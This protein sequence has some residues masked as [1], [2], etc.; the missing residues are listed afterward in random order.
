MI[1]QE[2]EQAIGQ[3]QGAFPD[4]AVETREDGQGGVYVVV[5]SVDLG[6]VYT[7]ATRRTWI[8]FHLSFQYPI[9]DVYP[10]HVRPDLARADAQALGTGMG[11]ARFEGFARESVQLSRRT[12][13][14]AWALQSGLLKLQK[15]IEWAR[16]L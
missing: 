12:K 5:D 14:G 4:A 7:E 8:G 3:I 16:T 10:H 1:K 9:A 11:V 13:E 2:V 6:P 15:V